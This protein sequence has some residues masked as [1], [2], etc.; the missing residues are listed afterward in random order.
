MAAGRDGAAANIGRVSKRNRGSVRSH[1][2]PGARPATERGAAPRR[3]AAAP[4][5]LEAAEIVAEDVIADEPVEAAHE[6]EQVARQTRSRSRV[7]PGSLLAVRAA[8]EYVYVSQDMRRI[9]LVAGALFGT[10]I[11]LWLLLVVMRVVALPFY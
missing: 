1:R 11:I 3:R 6:L 5:Q 8:S 2:R 7:K 4:S 10:L 9:L